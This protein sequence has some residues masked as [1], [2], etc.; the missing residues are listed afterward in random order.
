MSLLQP[1]TKTNNVETP[2]VRSLTLT[3]RLPQY[4]VCAGLG[5]LGGAIG[6][7]LAIALA[8]AAQ[9][10]LFP[11]TVFA[12]GMLLLALLAVVAGLVASWLL[13]RGAS[14]IFPALAYQTGE[15][16]MQ[17]ILVVST[18]TSLLET[19]LYMRA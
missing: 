5:A 10:I 16:N 6:V 3:S 14:Y 8:I 11:T 17:V 19:F 18:L 4:I 2:S 13:G 1:F 15:Q 12:P 9:L 7:A